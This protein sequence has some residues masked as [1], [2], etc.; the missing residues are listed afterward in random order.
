MSWG[1]ALVI[2]HSGAIR[3]IRRELKVKDSRLDNLGGCWFD[4]HPDGRLTAGRI[5]AVIGELNSSE[6]L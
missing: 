5:V 2:S 1:Q 6:S 4:V 3:T